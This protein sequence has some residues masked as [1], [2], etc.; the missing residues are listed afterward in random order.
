VRK[1]PAPERSGSEDG[2]VLIEIL[3]SALVL[4]IASA[5]VITLLTTTVRS[6]GEQRHG[7]EAYA[8]AQEDQARLASMQ[9]SLLNH[10][11]Q[12][13]E[14]S[15]NKT[16]FKVNSTGVFVNDKTSLP[17]CTEANSSADYVQITSKVTWPGMGNSEKAEI[18]SILSPSNGSLDP[19]RGTLAI[20]AANE[21]Q[22]PMPGVGV[23]GGGGTFSGT[24]DAAGCA[25]FP[26]LAAGNYQLAVNAEAAGL[27]NKDGK[28][29]EEKTVGV[30]GGKA[31]RVDLRFDRP[32][33]IPVNFKY[34][35]GSTA[36]Y[37]T[38]TADS[39]VAFN[40]G[41]TSAK[42]VWTAGGIRQP[43]VNANPLF[44]FT[45][46]YTL[47]A[48]SCASNNPNP[49]GESSPPGAAA[50]ANVIA[51]AGAGAPPVTI[52]L[53]ALNLT[54]KNGTK[55][56]S[57]ARVTI[58]DKNCKESLGNLVKRV[59]T[60]NAGGNQSATTGGAS[61][62]GLPWGSYEVCASAELKAGES[63]RVKVTTVAVENLISGTTLAIDLSTG[64]SG[65]T[66]P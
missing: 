22:T 54:V 28:S 18:E 39:V 48:G 26:D 40:T 59:Y 66:C 34:R 31:E 32:G 53:P 51:P 10:L 25:V 11:N 47:Y 33:T 14:V 42:T 64:E 44:P 23:V 38:A 7:S 2:F 35:I 30:V 29:T 27:I 65:K 57:G 12:T 61:E 17:S 16:G 41:M 9:L 55:I 36:T 8:L 1:T 60:T 24:T 50:I 20:F 49:K 52:Q 4:V 15:L 63:R 43:T 45:S 46:P 21:S 37:A 5:G 6:Q 56:V 19:N 13:R 58:T 62:P 3:V